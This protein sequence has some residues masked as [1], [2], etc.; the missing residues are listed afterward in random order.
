[1]SLESLCRVHTIDKYVQSVTQAT[2]ELAAIEA[3]ELEESGMYCRIVP[4]DPSEQVK[5]GQRDG[6]ANHKVFFTSD[7]GMDNTRRFQRG[8]DIYTFRWVKNP[9]LKNKFWVVYCDLNSFEP[10]A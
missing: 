4:M 9:D 2:D 1:M 8:E 7:P 10:A 3:W 5:F 6:T